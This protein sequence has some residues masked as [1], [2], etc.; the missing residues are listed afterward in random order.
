MAHTGE[1]YDSKGGW[2]SDAHVAEKPNFLLH[3]LYMLFLFTKEKKMI[4]RREKIKT[5]TKA[6]FRFRRGAFIHPRFPNK[7]KL[8]GLV[9]FCAERGD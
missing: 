6:S 2:A 9:G 7:N 3:K 1:I 8:S 4:I 5:L